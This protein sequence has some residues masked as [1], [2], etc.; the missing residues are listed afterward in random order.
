MATATKQPTRTGGG[1]SAPSSANGDGNGGAPRPA[2]AAMDMLLTDAG[3]SGGITRWLP[4]PAGIK[5]TAKLALRPDRDVLARAHRQGTGQQTGQ[6]GE[7]HGGL[8]RATAGDAEHE[9][10]VAHQPVVGAE[11]RRP[12]Q[13]TGD[14]TVAGMRVATHHTDHVTAAPGVHRGGRRS[15]AS[16]VQSERHEWRQRRRH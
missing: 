14:L 8:R 3:G 5:A 9:G 1:G 11:H 2:G 12:C 10:Q 16:G 13:P 7:Q 6:A 4:G 15:C